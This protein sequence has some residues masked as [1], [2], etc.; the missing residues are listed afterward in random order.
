MKLFVLLLIHLI[1][2]EA[3]HNS[4][5]DD[6]TNNQSEKPPF[7]IGAHGSESHES[8][9]PLEPQAMTF[10]EKQQQQQ[11]HRQVQKN[12]NPE[13]FSDVMSSIS[14][15]N[16][17]YIDNQNTN[18]QNVA[19]VT[20]D[21]ASVKIDVTANDKSADTLSTSSSSSQQKAQ[22]KLE[23]YNSNRSSVENEESSAEI[24]SADKLNR[25]DEKSSRITEYLKLADKVIK[26]ENEPESSQQQIEID[27]IHD[28]FDTTSRQGG[29]LM[30]IV[31]KGESS[32]THV[33]W[34]FSLVLSLK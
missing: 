24:S 3:R 27:V 18:I 12:Y 4:I 5:K 19:E 31:Y 33:T 29:L 6:Q 17:E 14:S 34:K 28:V 30:G 21:D 11:H 15:E 23:F 26:D 2:L 9:R 25:C 20:F 1:G 7:L 13:L 16:V 8:F 10:T 22:I 32:A